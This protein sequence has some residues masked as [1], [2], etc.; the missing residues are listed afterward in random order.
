MTQYLFLNQTTPKEKYFP[1]KIWTHSIGREILLYFS[2]LAD[3]GLQEPRTQIFMGNQITFLAFLIALRVYDPD[4][5]LETFPGFTA[6]KS[7]FDSPCEFP[8]PASSLVFSI[9]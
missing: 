5:V 3:G 9:F 8:D 4:C 1:A 6:S 2:E 7:I